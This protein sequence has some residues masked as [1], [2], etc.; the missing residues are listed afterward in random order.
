MASSSTNNV[1][2]H[3]IKLP[4]R[5]HTRPARKPSKEQEMRTKHLVLIGLLLLL[6]QSLTACRDRQA[7][8]RVAADEIA[9]VAH[10][11]ILYLAQTA[12]NSNRNHYA[13][14]I[15]E[16]AGAPGLVDKEMATG[17]KDGYLFTFHCVPQVGLPAYDIWATP[18]QPDETGVNLY[19]TDQT[20]V[21]R[22]TDRMLDSCRNANPVQ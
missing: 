15:A 22:R 11:Q 6:T 7:S 17:H 9:A 2:S 4:A 10:L 13:C 3:L 8:R 20:G 12:F 21:V 19:C 16:L 5:A 1:C 18:L 14:T